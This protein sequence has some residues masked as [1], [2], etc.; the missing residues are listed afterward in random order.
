MH[1]WAVASPTPS[2]TPFSC[3]SPSPSPVPTANPEVTE[4]HQQAVR[5]FARQNVQRGLKNHFVNSQASIQK[6]KLARD[7]TLILKEKKKLYSSIFLYYLL[8]KQLPFS[9]EAKD[10]EKEEET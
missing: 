6:Q 1:T 10:G 8:K 4:A 2:S 7:D 5:R 9:N 3:P